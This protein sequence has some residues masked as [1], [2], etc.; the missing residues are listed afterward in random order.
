MQQ[1][2]HEEQD[3]QNYPSERRLR[4]WV[5]AAMR[6]STPSFSNK[7]PIGRVASTRILA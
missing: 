7:Y 5:A 6:V 1:T 4:A 3:S 2:Q